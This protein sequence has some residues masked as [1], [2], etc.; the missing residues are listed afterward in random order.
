[1]RVLIV[2]KIF[3]HSRAPGLAPYNVR[4]F[5]ALARHEQVETAQLWA[6][7]PWFPG[8]ET[9]AAAR[10]RRLPILP[11]TGESDSLSIDYLRVAY[12]PKIGQPVAGFTYAVS[13]WPKVLASKG[14]FDVVLGSFAYPDGFAAALVARALAVPLVIKVHGSDIN[15]F[16]ERAHLRPL[17]RWALSDAYAVVGP[18]GPLVRRAVELGA[19]SATSRVVDNGVDRETFRVRDRKQ[20][21]QVL[22]IEHDRPIIVFVGRPEA[23]KGCGELLE[24]TH[25]IR[26]QGSDVSLVIV[27]DGVETNHYRKL[28]DRL[29]VPTHF[30]G[31]CAP[32]TVATWLGAANLLALPSWAEGTPNVVIESLLCGRPVVATSVGGIPNLVN[33]DLLGKLVPPKQPRRL[34][35]A[36]D[37]V[38]CH[39]ADPHQLAAA[40]S[41]GDWNVSAAAL[42]SVLLE[43]TRAPPGASPGPGASW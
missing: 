24:A 2:T 7:V 43:A 1:M 13:L 30:A 5:T 12:L 6:M 10:G 22:G 14:R 16:P 37:H 26:N 40:V 17:V 4:Q 23:A 27:G 21:R 41:V 9:L 18:S 28:A 8:Q 11:S 32:S 19:N 38:L 39:A 33:S 35:E 29:Q 36:L 20:C 3:P 15:V 34:A 25:I 42:A 31:A